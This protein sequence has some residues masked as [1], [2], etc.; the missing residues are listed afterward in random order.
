MYEVQASIRFF[1]KHICVH[2]LQ[3]IQNSFIKYVCYAPDALFWTVLYQRGF[4]FG[5][6][7]P[8]FFWTL[9]FF[10]W[11]NIFG[12]DIIIVKIKEKLRFN[13]NISLIRNIWM[14]KNVK[15]LIV[16]TGPKLMVTPVEK[17]NNFKHY[18]YVTFYLIIMHYD[19][20]YA[21]HTV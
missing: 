7:P 20:Y 19:N 6:F 21:L 13:M 2:E 16:F 9:W 8:P 5:C 1:Q 3:A 14:Y 17:A 10:L 11:S 4:R 12:Q 18:H 15:N